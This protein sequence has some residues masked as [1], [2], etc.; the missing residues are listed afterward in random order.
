AGDRAARDVDLRVVDDPGALAADRAG[1]GRFGVPLPGAA[2]SGAGVVMANNGVGR[3]TP[4]Q[5]QPH[6]TRKIG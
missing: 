1:V 2:G 4:R 5:A 6:L 3:V